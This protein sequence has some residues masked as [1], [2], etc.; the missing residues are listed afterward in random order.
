[1]QS[2]NS[3]STFGAHPKEF[4]LKQVKP[5]LSNLETIINWYIKYTDAKLDGNT[6]KEKPL[7]TKINLKYRKTKKKGFLISGTVAVVILILA[8]LYWLDVIKIEGLTGSGPL[9]ALAVL[10][11]DNLTGQEGNVALADAIQLKLTNEL[12]KLGKWRVISAVSARQF[13]ES[14]MLLKDIAK[15]LDVSTIV[16]GS[17]TMSGDDIGIIIQLYDVYPKERQMFTKEYSDNMKNVLKIQSAAV[18]D[19]AK[20]L[21]IKLTK[22][23]EERLDKTPE[24]S[25]ESYRAYY[26]G[27]ELLDRQTPEDF[28]KGIELLQ[29]SIKEDPGNAF[30]YAAVALG[31]A[32]MG[33][34]A[35][36]AEEAFKAA[37]TAANKAINIDPTVN[38]AH[39]ALA[40]LYLYDRWDWPKAGEAFENALIANP[41]DADAHAHYAWYYTLYFDKENTLYHAREAAILEPGYPSYKTWLA[42]LYCNYGEYNNAEEWAKKALEQNDNA[43]YGNLVMAWLNVHNKEFLKARKFYEKLPTGDYWDAIRVDGYV[44]TGQRDRAMTIWNKM[45]ETEKTQSVNSC[46]MGMMAA[47]LGFLDEA[48]KYLFD[49]ADNK[50]YP[51]AYIHFFGCYDN[52]KDDPRF[53]EFRLKLKLPTKKELVASIQ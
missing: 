50:I 47:S 39:T 40:M 44:K 16:N 7:Q 8:S 41:N 1:M 19:I 30:A 34:G 27:R 32:T 31:Y 38:E 17:V 25:S 52:I 3:M 12:G 53:D 14:N 20:D 22:T 29:E 37:E 49:A 18:K 6:I 13:R 43:P 42:C 51:V 36:N 23:T 2:V 33:H 15:A 10:P 48:F 46:N 24:I 11:L 4:E 28:E 26:R 9:N 5:V 21:N 45:V 35:L